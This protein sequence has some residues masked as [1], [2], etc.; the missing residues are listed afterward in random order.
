MYDIISIGDTTTDVFLEIDQATVN[1][2]IKKDICQLCVDYADKIP[3]NKIIRLH[4]VGNAANSAVGASRLGLKT[5]IYTVVGNDIGGKEA[6][7]NFTKEKVSS[8]F[9]KIDKTKPTN[10]S[11]VLNFDGERTIFVYHESREYKLPK[12]GKSKWI[13]FTSLAFGHKPLHKQLLNYL[14]KSGA[15]LAFNPGTFQIKEGL[16]VLKPILKKTEVLSVNKR[17]A[18]I[19]LKNNSSVPILLKEFYNLGVKKV[20]ITDGPKGS[21]TYNGEDMYKMGIF[22]TPI[23]ERTGA[24][25]AYTIAFVSALV[26]ENNIKTAMRWGTFNASSVVQH[27]GAQAGLLN[28]DGIKKMIKNNKNIK[29][30]KIEK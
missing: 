8:K 3:V 28:L 27:L 9:L 29:P 18:Q 1:C 24:G 25:D 2:K 6:K 10:Y 12:F 17:E 21:Y 4:G 13:Y 19:L 5:A 20:V 26:L 30:Q 23:L 11:T 16:K 15:K 22:D 14:E 7:K